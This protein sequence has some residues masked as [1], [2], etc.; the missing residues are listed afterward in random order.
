M[1]RAAWH[2]HEPARS[3][4]S[5]APGATAQKSCPARQLGLFPF[6]VWAEMLCVSTAGGNNP[7]AAFLWLPALFFHFCCLGGFPPC[8]SPHH[9]NSS[10]HW[11]LT[12][13]AACNQQRFCHSLSSLPAHQPLASDGVLRERSGCQVFGFQKFGCSRPRRE[14]IGPDNTLNYHPF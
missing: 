12:S 6:P 10:C 14:K 7:K 13:P 2:P 3:G 5:H 11:S 1:G 9:H 4:I 8:P